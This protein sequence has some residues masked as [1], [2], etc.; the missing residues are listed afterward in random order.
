MTTVVFGLA[1]ATALISSSWLPGSLSDA[2]STP[3][4]ACSPTTTPALSALRAAAAAASG[5]VVGSDT[6]SATPVP[7]PPWNCL[8]Y[9]ADSVP[10]APPGSPAGTLLPVSV[11]ALE[12]ADPTLGE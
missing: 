12:P 8:L 11:T 6:P 1:A 7:M 3:S 5:S 10:A 9:V 4:P 2:R